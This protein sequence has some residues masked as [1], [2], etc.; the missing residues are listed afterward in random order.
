MSTL[1]NWMTCTVNAC[2]P[3]YT[4]VIELDDW[5]LEEMKK[6]RVLCFNFQKNKYKF[7]NEL[8]EALAQ[9]IAEKI[10]ETMEQTK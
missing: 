1:V 5:A 7:V 6:E 2:S 4:F 10:L 9:E 8:S 3:K